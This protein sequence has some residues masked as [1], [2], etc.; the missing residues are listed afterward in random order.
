MDSYFKG[1]F[2]LYGNQFLQ[3]RLLSSK[4]MNILY[5]LEVGPIVVLLFLFVLSFVF[6]DGKCVLVKVKRV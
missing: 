1:L 4:A 6:V 3:H 5:S 2:L